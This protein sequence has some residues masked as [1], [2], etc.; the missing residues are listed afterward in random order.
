[1]RDLMRIRLHEI[2]ASGTIYIRLSRIFVQ[3]QC[4][5][6]ACLRAEITRILAPLLLKDYP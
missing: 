5:P 3:R 2:S 6:H 4:T 1:M